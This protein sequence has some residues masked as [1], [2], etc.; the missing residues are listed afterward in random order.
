MQVTVQTR[1][2]VVK[3][4]V[5]DLRVFPIWEYALGEEDVPGHDETWVRPVESEV[6]RRRTYSQIVAA[7]FW[8]PAGR[9]L[10]GFMVVSTADGH[11]DVQPGAIV[12]R[13]GYRVIPSISRPLAARRGYSWSLD[14]R[15][16]L[17]KALRVREAE[18]FPISYELE[19]VI[20]GERKRRRGLLK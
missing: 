2:P 13:A 15:A 8:T 7:R 10:H 19:V 1:K 6:L 17:T 20:R 11:V 3:L 16:R 18:A 9:K 4:T 5:R 14:E 12:G